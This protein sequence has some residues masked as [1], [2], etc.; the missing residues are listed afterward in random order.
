MNYFFFLITIA[1]MELRFLRLNCAQKWYRKKYYSPVQIRPFFSQRNSKLS[2]KNLLSIVQIFYSRYRK[3]VEP[4]TWVF[5]IEYEKYCSSFNKKKE[6]LANKVCYITT[7]LSSLHTRAWTSHISYY[8]CDSH[9]LL[10]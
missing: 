3:T 10:P 5:W 8:D 7:P 6:W 9:L 2:S 1:T 4:N